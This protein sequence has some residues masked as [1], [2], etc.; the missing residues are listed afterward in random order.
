MAHY[1]TINELVRDGMFLRIECRKCRHVEMVDPEDIKSYI[2]QLHRGDA[3]TKAH[4]WQLIPHGNPD[5]TLI[6]CMDGIE[7]PIC[8]ASD[9]MVDA[10]K[11]LKDDKDE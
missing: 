10:I 2:S 9:W 5:L 8:R 11:P 1:R 6:G 4:G 3:M 7:C